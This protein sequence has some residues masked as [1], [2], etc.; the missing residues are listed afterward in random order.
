AN[1]SVTRS[2]GNAESS[3]IRESSIKFDRYEFWANL[4]CKRPTV[5]AVRPEVCVLNITPERGF[6]MTQFK[7]IRWWIAGL[8]AIATALNYLDRQSFPVA[9]SRIRVDIPLTDQQFSQLNSLGDGFSSS[10][11]VWASCGR[12]RGSSCIGRLVKISVS[13]SAS[14]S[15]AF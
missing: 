5:H 15:D 7:N 2:T 10:R 12:W 9:V 1:F 14:R 4:I 11:G 8:L 6:K 3:D 13:L